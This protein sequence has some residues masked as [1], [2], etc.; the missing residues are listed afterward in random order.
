MKRNLLNSLILVAL[1]VP[2]VAMAEDSPVSANVGFVSDYL[3]RG[4]SQTSGG[5]A[6]QGGIDYAL[7][8]GFHLGLWGSNISWIKDFGATGTSSLEVD[9]YAG[10]GGSFAD[11]YSYDVGYIRYNYLG[12]YTPVVGTVKADTSEVYGSIGYKWVSA[13]YSYSL[14]DFLGV[15]NSK[16]TNYVEVNAS[17]TL[18][19]MG[20]DLGAHY[21]KQTYV[22]AEA[23]A[24]KAA[25]FDPSYADYKLSVAKDVGGYVIGLAY[26]NTNAK[27]D[28]FYTTGLGKNLARSAGVLSV[29]HAF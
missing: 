14:G 16:G 5:P 25:G 23:D 7:E 3:V 10:Y 17:Y 12:D 6:L 28:A 20:L 29:L 18:E 22:G 24:A 11:D 15:P 27:K 2:G 9:T 19:G 4:I 21:G 1:A 8:S 26:S 13:K